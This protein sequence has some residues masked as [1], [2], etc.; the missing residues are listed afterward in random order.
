MHW[1]GCGIAR[2]GWHAVVSVVGTGVV[3]LA[4]AGCDAVEPGSSAAAAAAAPVHSAPS[5][6][7]PSRVWT[8]D[9]D[10]V[11]APPAGFIVEAGE[12]RVEADEHAPSGA[13]VL[14]QRADSGDSVFN[15]VLIPDA[16]RQDVD[17]SIHLRA[18][19]GRID[20]GGGVV[21]RA[22]D[23]HNYYVARYNPL[24]DN[25]RVYDVKDGQRH[26]LQSADL[27]VDPQA[28]H[29]LRVRM[30]GEHIEVF[31]DDTKYLEVRDGTFADGGMVGLWMKADA[32]TAFDD[33]ALG[34]LEQSVDQAQ[35][36]RGAIE[37]VVAVT[38]QGL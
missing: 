16:R 21:W 31:L 5:V 38:A 9:D 2:R 4:V 25:L 32:V 30:I 12:W 10:T 20:Q 1:K 3:T 14:V 13:R 18:R 34:W 11:G 19:E 8:F 6:S 22:R 27:R 37:G 26:Q 36:D 15:L 28:W 23:R 33:V 24:E 17:L 29:A 7:S 35:L